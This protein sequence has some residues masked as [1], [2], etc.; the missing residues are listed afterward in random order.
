M[1]VS[2]TVV[3]VCV[4]CRLSSRQTFRENFGVKAPVFSKPNNGS[5]YRYI[6][7]SPRGW[8]SSFEPFQPLCP[9]PFISDLLGF[10]AVILEMLPEP[11]ML[12]GFMGSDA[13]LRI[14]YEDLLEQVKEFTVE[15]GMGRN[16]LMKVFHG[17]DEFL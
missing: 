16:G 1:V 17:S 15:V 12:Q 13:L 8:C 4:V 10:G 5:L 6:F 3:C 7:W 11:W 2:G 14:I 9:L